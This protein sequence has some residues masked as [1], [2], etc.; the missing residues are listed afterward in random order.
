VVMSRDAAGAITGLT[1]RYGEKDFT[2]RRLEA[3]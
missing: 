3:K 1:T 2:A